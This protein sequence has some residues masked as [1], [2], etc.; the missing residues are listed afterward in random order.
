[1]VRER[2]GGLTMRGG[3]WIYRQGVA[4]STTMPIESI[5]CGA[6]IGSIHEGPRAVHT[7]PSLRPFA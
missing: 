5:F 7:I 4:A 6:R 2:N 1:M 3:L